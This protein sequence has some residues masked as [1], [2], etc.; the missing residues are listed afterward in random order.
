M[1]RRFEAFARPDLVALIAALSILVFLIGKGLRSDR[2]KAAGI[3]CVNNL[4]QSSLALNI[5]NPDSGDR[6]PYQTRPALTINTPHVSMTLTD[7]V[8]GDVT[9]HAAWAHWGML[10][11]EL[12]SPKILQCPADY[13]KRRSL[14][15]D[16]TTNEH[17]GFFAKGGF[18]QMNKVAHDQDLIDYEAK[19]G[20]DVSISYFICLNA[21]ETIPE[22]IIAGDANINWVA[23]AGPANPVA[24]GL[25]NLS[26]HS[27]FANLRFVSGRHK[28]KPYRHHPDGGNLA[29]TDGSV[30]QV[31]DRMMRRTVSRATNA[32][33][34]TA[35]WF[36]IPK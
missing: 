9:R 4:K 27:D 16:W 34:T 12:G 26:R 36:V 24:A 15:T 10:S 33:N 29:I 2:D 18:D 28:T 3:R 17:H 11:N 14:A 30:V 21:D 20:Y 25:Q 31:N 1:R 23:D 5:F 22:G 7:T 35:L 19:T 32:H 6:H 8:I 13:A